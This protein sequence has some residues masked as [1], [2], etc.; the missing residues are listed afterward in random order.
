MNNLLSRFADFFSAVFTVEIFMRI[1]SLLGLVIFIHVFFRILG[2]MVKRLGAKA[3]KPQVMHIVQKAIHYLGFVVVLMT[4]FNRLGINLSALMGAAGI[5]GIAIGFAAQTSV[6]NVIS[7]LFVMSERAF[8][9][10]DLLEVNSIVGTVESIDL[11]SIRLKTPENQFVRIPNETIIKTNLI[12]KTHFPVR[13]FTLKVGVAYGTDLRQLREILQDIAAK[14]EFA[15]AEP[16][17]VVI[18]DSFEDSSITV[19]F[20]AWAPVEQFLELKNSMMIDVAE[21]F[22]REGIVI[23]F[24]QLAVHAVNAPVC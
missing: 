6:S 23:P 5:A 10:G 21:R 11:L 14:N 18:F 12:N 1:G 8:Q 24:P 22:A 16:A 15:L 20:G 13:R 7:G 9:I 19:L 3:L 17:P 2:S 4:I